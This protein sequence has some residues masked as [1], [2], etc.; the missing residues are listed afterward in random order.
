M[1]HW[2]FENGRIVARNQ[3]GTQL[4]ALQ[5]DQAIDGPLLAAIIDHT[6]SLGRLLLSGYGCSEASL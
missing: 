4:L 5:V 6:P 3:V 1:A 2:R